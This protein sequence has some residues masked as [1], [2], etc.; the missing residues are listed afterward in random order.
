MNNIEL[1]IT[2][3][4]ISRNSYI[5]YPSPPFGYKIVDQKQYDEWFE[6]MRNLK[7]PIKHYQL[8]AAKVLLD[9]CQIIATDRST[10]I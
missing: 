7:S 1:P 10:T 9:Y 5:D 6:Q 3:V 4:L 8:K 2:K